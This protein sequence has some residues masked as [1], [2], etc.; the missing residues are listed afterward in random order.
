[1]ITKKDLLNWLKEIDS[2][3]KDKVVLTA[4][5]GTAMTLLDLKESTGVRP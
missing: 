5:G 1:M 2:K 4:V 3:L